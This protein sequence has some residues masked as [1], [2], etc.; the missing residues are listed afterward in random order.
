[1]RYVRTPRRRI[2]DEVWIPEEQVISFRPQETARRKNWRTPSFFQSIAV[3]FLD[4]NR[5]SRVF[6]IDV[7]PPA[8]E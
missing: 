5:E 6:S 8:C 1:M 7:V 3:F 2:H 4:N